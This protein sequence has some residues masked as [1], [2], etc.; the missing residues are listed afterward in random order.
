[1]VEQ[2]TPRVLTRIFRDASPGRTAQKAVRMVGINTLP[3][4]SEIL[5][6]VSKD[7]FGIDPQPHDELTHRERYEDALEIGRSMF[8][9]SHEV[10]EFARKLLLPEFLVKGFLTEN[11]FP[12]KPAFTD[13]PKLALL[14]DVPVLAVLRRLNDIRNYGNHHEDFFVGL[15]DRNDSGFT[16]TN[17]GEGSN[18]PE[19]RKLA[20]IVREDDD[21]VP[22]VYASRIEYSGNKGV[23]SVTLPHRVDFE[24][25]NGEKETLM[26]FRLG[27]KVGM[28]PATQQEPFVF[29]TTIINIE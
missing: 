7:C 24:R 3:F 26:R 29:A 21:P 17:R 23:Y 15:S 19:L 5:T 18:A 22:N 28:F 10:E 2:E 25:P 12:R 13:I 9:K 14:A 16:Y 8:A 20:E 11:G 27:R 6:A 4:P 1:M